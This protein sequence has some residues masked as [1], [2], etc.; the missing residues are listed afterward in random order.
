MLVVWWPISTSLHAIVI[1]GL[2]SSQSRYTH[3]LLT[4]IVLTRKV[5]TRDRA[6]R[7]RVPTPA[8]S[9]RRCQW[10]RMKFA[11]W[12]K[13]ICMFHWIRQLIQWQQKWRCALQA[14]FWGQILR[15]YQ[16]A[17]MLTGSATP[18][19][20]KRH[21]TTNFRLNGIFR[22]IMS[23]RCSAK[24]KVS[25][26]MLVVDV[27]QGPITGAWKGGKTCHFSAHKWWYALMFN[28]GQCLTK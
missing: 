22:F 19:V 12:Q 5:S 16:W 11:P 9:Q 28:A 10:E 18:S 3:L 17:K 21:C 8:V 4:L 14:L 27:V 6:K 20:N 15:C 2:G 26:T 7:S 24:S 1:A 25:T 13:C 23:L